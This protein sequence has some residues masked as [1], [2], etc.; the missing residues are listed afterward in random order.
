MLYVKPKYGICI[1][2]SVNLL[3]WF[4]YSLATN[5][6]LRLT[7]THGCVYAVQLSMFKQ[8]YPQ[9]VGRTEGSDST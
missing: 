2:S 5:Y 8:H 4:M 7:N 3:L 6:K 1:M 9:A